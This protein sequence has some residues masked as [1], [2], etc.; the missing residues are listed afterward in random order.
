[1]DEDAA[2]ITLGLVTGGVL[3]PPGYPIYGLA[4][5]AFVLL[6]RALGIHEAF[7]A[8]AWAVLGAALALFFLHRLTLCL[9]EHANVRATRMRFALAALPVL[10]LGFNPQLTP[11]ATIVEVLSLHLAWL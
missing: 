9:M 6:A 10:I 11:E 4:G 1:A 7:A 3:H 2:E 5:H 8:N